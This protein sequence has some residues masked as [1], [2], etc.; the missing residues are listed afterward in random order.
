MGAESH[1]ARRLA[2]LLWTLFA[3]FVVRVAGQALVAFLGVD[4][5][6]PMPAW[7]SGLLAYE[8]LLPAQIVIVGLM[9]KICLDFT[10]ARAASSPRRGHS[11]RP[12]GCTSAG[13]ISR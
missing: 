5:L 6:P 8:Y 10:R 13:A 11:W 12:A 3:F 7:Y 2:P 4:F 1:P 9:A